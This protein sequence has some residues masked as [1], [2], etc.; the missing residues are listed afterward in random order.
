MIQKRLKGCYSCGENYQQVCDFVH[1][2]FTLH[3][4]FCCRFSKLYYVF[5]FT[6]NVNANLCCCRC[7][8]KENC[9]QKIY[10]KIIFLLLINCQHDR[11]LTY[12]YFL[13]F[14]LSTS[15][16]SVL[17]SS[18]LQSR[19]W[20][21][22]EVS[23]QLC[24]RII[25]NCVNVCLCLCVCVCVYVCVFRRRGEFFELTKNSQFVWEDENHR[26]LLR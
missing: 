4:L 3:L 8:F 13:S 23:Q 5:F 10:I 11:P 16:I 24:M 17:N 9:F 26:D 15:V 18:L 12:S 21:V 20:V 25:I 1:P 22:E 2:F 7:C 6:Q 14:H 19:Q